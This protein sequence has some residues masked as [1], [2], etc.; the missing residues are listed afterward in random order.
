MTPL[1]SGGTYF[2][3]MHLIPDIKVG[4]YVL[5]HAGC[6]IQTIDEE[7]AAITL[8]IIKELSDNEICW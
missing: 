1:L 5:V 8:E 2:N 6:A 7:E 4:Q 3:F